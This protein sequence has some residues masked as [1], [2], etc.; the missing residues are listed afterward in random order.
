MSSDNPTT[1]GAFGRPD[2]YRAVI[3]AARE[4]HEGDRDWATWCAQ[5]LRAWPGHVEPEDH[6]HYT[7]N[8]LVAPMHMA[9]WL[10]FTPEPPEDD[11]CHCCDEWR[12]HSPGQEHFGFVWWRLSERQAI[13]D[14]SH[15]NEEV[16]FA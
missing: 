11:A 4:Q 6:E 16:W 1:T 13:C 2:T 7:G 10:D 14:H 3:D 15:H 12:A 8:P 5:C 9:Q